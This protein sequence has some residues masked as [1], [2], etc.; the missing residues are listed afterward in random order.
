M[1]VLMY[2]LCFWVVR[3]EAY[4]CPP[5]WPKRGLRLTLCALTVR[6]YQGFTCVVVAPANRETGKTGYCAL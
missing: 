4:E 6:L 3:A 5:V 2:L 1:Y